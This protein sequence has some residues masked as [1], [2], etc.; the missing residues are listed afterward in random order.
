M[1]P[2]HPHR[3][4]RPLDDLSS[5]QDT[6]VHHLKPNHDVFILLNATCNLTKH[7]G[8][9]AANPVSRRLDPLVKPS[10]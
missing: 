9:I 8:Y 7:N 6:D 1:H 3:H 4:L 10:P 2:L 5:K